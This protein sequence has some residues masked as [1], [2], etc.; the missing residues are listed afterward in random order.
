[1]NYKF[2]KLVIGSVLIFTTQIFAQ[3]PLDSAI[4]AC[5]PFNGNANDVSG[6]GNNGIVNNGAA[7]TSDRFGTPNSAYVFN[8]TNQNIEIPNFEGKCNTPQ[9]SISFWAR[10]TAVK[11]QAAFLLGPDVFT[12]RLNISVYYTH[13]DNNLWT[14]YDYG[15]LY[16]QGRLQNLGSPFPVGNAWDHFVF[17]YNYTTNSMK[18]YK[19]GALVLAKTGASAFTPVNAARGLFI[20]GTSNLYFNGKIDD[21]KIYKRELKQADVT[22]LY[23]NSSTCNVAASLNEITGSNKLTVFPNPAQNN[24]QISGISN[25]SECKIIDALGKEV[26]SAKYEDSIS[27]YELTLP[28][29]PKG[30]YMLE[31]IAQGKRYYSKVVIDN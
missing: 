31:A 8:G 16:N 24:L 22:A 17:V 12:S 27:D 21:I 3:T 23:A 14:F 25:L 20:G 1:M 28:T 5:Y 4:V 19:N 30:I 18:Y 15:D 2:T 11:T 7:L 13:S 10:S 9:L 26:F 29:L 6:N